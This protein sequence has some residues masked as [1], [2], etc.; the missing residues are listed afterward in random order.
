MAAHGLAIAQVTPF[1][2]EA[3]NDVNEYVARTSAVLAANGHRVL[4][5]APAESSA[6]VREGRRA[7]RTRGDQLLEDADGQPVVL[8][9]GE[10]LPFSGARRRAASVPVDV[11]RTIEDALGSLALDIVHVH[12]PFA[13]S[14][15]SAAL[16]HSR[17]LNVG[18][19]HAPTERILSTQLT[20]PLT[21]LLF[22]RLDARTASYR[23]TRDLM[24]RFFPAE[25]QV[26]TPGAQ[27]IERAGDEQPPELVMV[28]TEE[29]AALRTFLRALKLLPDEPAWHA[30]VFSR[31]PLAI[32]ATLDRRLRDRV[33]F[34]GPDEESEEDV[35][36]RASVV[37]LGSEGLRVSPGT[38]IRAIA[39]GAVPVASRL[40]VYE[41]VL[42]D[43][44]R[45]LEFEPGDSRRSHP[46]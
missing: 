12:E 38:L 35:L 1:A 7:I 18:S 24:Q 6:M 42:G 5:I 19:F 13:P 43:G 31:R 29:R 22:S 16:R 34:V 25:Y 46:T 45:G 30:T 23:A 17:A 20:R 4:I 3:R 36:A 14:A 9:V 2:W 33:S 40:L 28:A 27:V 32:P 26:I 39:A 11:A 41:E 8:G 21:R 15:A 37:V 10:V 44:E